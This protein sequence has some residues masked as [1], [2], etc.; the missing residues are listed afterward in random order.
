MPCYS[1]VLRA[2][3]NPRSLPTTPTPGCVRAARLIGS[4]GQERA[5]PY[6]TQS[7]IQ[8]KEA[9]A[10]PSLDLVKLHANVRSGPD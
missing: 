3:L 5:T 7:R 1:C 9:A 10:W 6:R 4:A 8:P 2:A